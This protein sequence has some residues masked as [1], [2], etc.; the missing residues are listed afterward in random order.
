MDALTRGMADAGS[1]AEDQHHVR[2]V[3]FYCAPDGA[4]YCVLE[5]PSPDAFRAR[6]VERGM[7]CSE[8]VP[9]PGRKWHLPLSARARHQVERAIRRDW[10]ARHPLV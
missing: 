9:L 3:D 6:H 8:V 1:G 2:Q 5:A 7:A 10:L 4:V